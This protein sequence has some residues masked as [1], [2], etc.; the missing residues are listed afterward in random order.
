MKWKPVVVGALLFV[1]VVSILQVQSSDA[2]PAFARRE[3]AKCQMCR[4]RLPEL[5]ED[6][7]ADIVKAT[8][9]AKLN[10]DFAN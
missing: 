3:G 2:V 5:N 4:F 8:L 7:H 10:V 1:A 9:K 6:G